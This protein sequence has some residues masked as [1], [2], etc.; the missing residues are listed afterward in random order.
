MGSQVTTRRREHRG[1]SCSVRMASLRC[2]IPCGAAYMGLG[3]VG[4]N[5]VFLTVARSLVPEV[6]MK[7]C[8]AWSPLRYQKPSC[9]HC[10]VEASQSHLFSLILLVS[11][12]NKE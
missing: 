12:K 11:S 1:A 4:F 2:P 5:V 7:P 10:G 9:R 8:K 6:R 3:S